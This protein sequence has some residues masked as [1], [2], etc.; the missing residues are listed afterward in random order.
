[1]LG[2]ISEKNEDHHK[3]DRVSYSLKYSYLFAKV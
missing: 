1:M 3:V 2:W